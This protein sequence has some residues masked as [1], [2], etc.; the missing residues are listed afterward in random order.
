MKLKTII[1]TIKAGMILSVIFICVN[2]SAQRTDKE[3]SFMLETFPD[4]IE[5]Y[6]SINLENISSDVSSANIKLYTA[7]LDL[8]HDIEVLLNEGDNEFHMFTGHLNNGM[9]FL[10][11]GNQDEVKKKK[12]IIADR[13]VY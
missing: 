9:Y 13:A 4:S 7:Q 10:E 6:I 1:G 12:I 8:L 5:R 11:V 2:V 3:T